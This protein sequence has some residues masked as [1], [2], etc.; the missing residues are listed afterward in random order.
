MSGSFVNIDNLKQNFEYLLSYRSEGVERLPKNVKIVFD[1]FNDDL[2]TLRYSILYHDMYKWIINQLNGNDTEGTIGAYYKECIRNPC[3][4]DCITEI[5][6]P[7]EFDDY[8]M[9]EMFIIHGVWNNGYRFCT[10]NCVNG[11]VYIYLDGP[12]FTGFTI[13]EKNLLREIIQP[14]KVCKIY[15]KKDLICESTIDEMKERSEEIE[16]TKVIYYGAVIGM[17]VIIGLLAT[18]SIKS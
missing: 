3:S 4:T 7:D 6:L 15:H 8:N 12:P 17:I 14:E 11:T 2:K 1:K 18:Q 10:G 5:A 13:S 16:N 9:C